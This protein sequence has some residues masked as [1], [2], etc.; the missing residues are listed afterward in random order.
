MVRGIV[1]CLL[2]VCPFARLVSTFN[3]V[4]EDGSLQACPEKG[5]HAPKLTDAAPVM[6]NKQNVPNGFI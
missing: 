5:Y 1:I 6:V 4:S 2:V 3:S